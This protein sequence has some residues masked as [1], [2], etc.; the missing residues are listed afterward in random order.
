MLQPQ[1]RENIGHTTRPKGVLF[2]NIFRNKLLPQCTQIKDLPLG[3]KVYCTF[4]YCDFIKYMQPALYAKYTDR[5]GRPVR[6]VIFII[7][8][9]LDL[10]VKTGKAG[11]IRPKKKKGGTA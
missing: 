1:Y 5:T 8:P 4:T 6:A 9:P 10:S 3:R 2:L 11:Q 7:F